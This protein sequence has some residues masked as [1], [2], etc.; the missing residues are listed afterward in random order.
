MGNLPR[1]RVKPCRPFTRVGVDYAGPIRVR[2]APDRGQAFY[3]GY[4]C[5]FFALA[6]KLY[7]WK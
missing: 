1:E 7:I 5:I 4:I 2:A 6:L 3:K